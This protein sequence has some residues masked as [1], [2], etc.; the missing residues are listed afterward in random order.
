MH[1]TPSL[2]LLLIAL[3]LVAGCRTYGAYDSTE[4]I[5]LQIQEANQRF[6]DQL[7]R[8][9]ADFV[10]LEAAARRNP[11]LEPAALVYA[12]AISLH[13]EMLERHRAYEAEARENLGSYRT[14][15]RVYGAIL[16]E[17]D[18]VY[19]RYAFALSL[20][21]RPD[22]LQEVPTGLVASRYHVVPPFY[23]RV[24]VPS[25]R[26]LVGQANV[27]PADTAAAAPAVPADTSEAALDA[28]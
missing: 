22:S 26:E 2:L 14:Q 27:A 10:Q 4:K 23:Q 17:Q 16:A 11:A 13:E 18:V 21:A 28:S 20:P 24:S 15:H 1:S 6:A 7:E 9:R 19:D 12:S 25:V 8:E 3:L 5:A